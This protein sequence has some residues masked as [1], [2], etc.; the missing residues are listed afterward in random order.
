MAGDRIRI[1]VID[2]QDILRN[3][4]ALRLG[5]RG[6]EVAAGYGSAREALEG[7]GTVSPDAAVVDLML[8]D[9][10]AAKLISELLM[11]VPRLACVG[12]TG[13][14]DGLLM[15]QALNAGALGMVVKAGARSDLELLDRSLRETA[16]GN[17]Y[18]C[19]SSTPLI[20][21]AR[22][23]GSA[24]VPS[25]KQMEVL[26]AIRVNRGTKAV[27][28]ALGANLETT[29]T[30]KRRLFAKLG[31]HDEADAVRRGIARGYLVP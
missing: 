29:H 4:V 24:R 14:E 26:R 27:A 3:L 21:V 23:G 5:T 19:Q 18:L 7:I 16:E 9:M 6:F 2:D 28:R 12:Y 17:E 13:S 22:K 1:V 30:Q 20:E 8:P 15:L 10:A 31:A 11:R 25:A